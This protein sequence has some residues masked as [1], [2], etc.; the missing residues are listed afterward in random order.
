LFKFKRSG[1][2]VTKENIDDLNAVI[3]VDVEKKDY[4]D[5]VESTLKDYRKKANIDGFRPGKAP[6]GMIR[7]MYGQ[8]VLLDEVNKVISEALNN[9]IQEN[10]ELKMLGEPIAKEDQET[11]DFDKEDD[12]SIKFD[13]GL[14]PDVDVELN[15]R[16]KLPFYK[17]K[18]DEQL[19]DEYIENYAK[20]FGELVDADE[21]DE[22]S[23]LMG[24]MIQLNDKEEP[25]ENG[26]V[27]EDAKVSVSLCK[28][29]DIKSQL[30]GLKIGDIVSFDVWKAFPN[31]TEVAGM[32][33]IE[34]EDVKSLENTMFRLVVEGVQTFKEAEVDQELFDKVFGEGEVDSVE[35]FRDKIREQAEQNFIPDMEYKL[36][37]D[38]KDKLVKKVDPVLP[39]EFLKRWLKQTNNELSDEQIEQDWPRFV[40]DMKWQLISNKIAKD[41]E[42]DLTKED[43]LKAAK[44][45][46]SAQFRQ[47]GMSYVPDEHLEKYA[48]EILKK[49]DEARKIADRE[50]ERKVLDVIR[51]NVKIDEKEVSVDEFKGLFEDKK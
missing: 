11:I 22:E 9:Y 27:K 38:A 23:Y 50:M 28:D 18:A 14:H 6:M 25:L 1:M 29:E 42:L 5:R 7:K 32:L 51:D 34:K 16:M 35:A 37:L 48:Q 8:S 46:A 19:I 45:Y 47:Y 4:N 49:E 41:N 21:S 20:N 17:I 3:T 44:E 2:K 13:V 26:I 12:F 40:E 36:L 15:K 30:V 33:E 43:L 24:K 31:E 10:E 39:E